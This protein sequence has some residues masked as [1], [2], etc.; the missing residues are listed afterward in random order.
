MFKF[1]HIY[2]RFHIQTEASTEEL[3]LLECYQDRT[4]WVDFRR[5][6]TISFLKGWRISLDRIQ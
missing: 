2:F 5:Y 3:N 1:I 4:S 6:V